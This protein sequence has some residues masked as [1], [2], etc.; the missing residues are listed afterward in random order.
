MARCIIRLPRPPM[1]RETTKVV[2]EWYSTA[3]IFSKFLVMTDL[4]PVD[5]IKLSHFHGNNI[6]VIILTFRFSFFSLLWFFSCRLIA[7][8]ECVPY[9]MP[10]PSV[11]IYFDSL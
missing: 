8:R 4:L 9:V 10:C 7:S 6:V 3:R 11:M 1:D 2:M 5:L